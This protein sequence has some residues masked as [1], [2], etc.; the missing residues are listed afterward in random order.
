MTHITT[1]FLLRYD[2]N[3]IYVKTLFV[4]VYILELCVLVTMDN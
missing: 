3:N 4:H 2:T 1:T